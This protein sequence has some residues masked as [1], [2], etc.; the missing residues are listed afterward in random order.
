MKMTT[1]CTG[2]GQDVA[3]LSHLSYWGGLFGDVDACE[4]PQSC[5]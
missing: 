2:N 4:S 1:T 3:S 5:M